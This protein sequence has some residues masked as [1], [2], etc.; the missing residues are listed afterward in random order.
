MSRPGEQVALEQLQREVMRLVQARDWPNALTHIDRVLKV[1]PDMPRMLLN[2]AQ[3]LLATGRRLEARKSA[4]AALS[5]AERDAVLL[6]ALGS[7]Y[8][9]AGYQRDAL[10]AFER[11][12]AL[13]PDNAHFMFNRATAGRSRP[14][15][16]SFPRGQTRSPTGP[17]QPSRS[18]RRACRLS[19]GGAFRHRRLLYDEPITD[20]EKEWRDEQAD[21]HFRVS[22]GRR[23]RGRAECTR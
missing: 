12:V 17:R 4:D 18:S 22:A 21:G 20:R 2:Q 9:F 16:T 14:D 7:F 13:A 15:A 8:S 23:S 6:D 11:A 19:R 5:L 3:C 1:R 10:K